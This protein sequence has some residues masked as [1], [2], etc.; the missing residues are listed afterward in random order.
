MGTER[1]NLD[2]ELQEADDGV[3]ED[4][5]ILQEVE[6]ERRDVPV[7]DD[8]QLDLSEIA[9]DTARDL[10]DEARRQRGLAEK[11]DEE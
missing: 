11:L 4:A 5:A 3:L 10:R 1:P 2:D 9:A 7:G 6:R 8:V